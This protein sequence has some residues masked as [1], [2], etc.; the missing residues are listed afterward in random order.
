MVKDGAKSHPGPV[1]M[2]L[3]KQYLQ[4]N[5][6]IFLKISDIICQIHRCSTEGER[7]LEENFRRLYQRV[8]FWRK[9]GSL[10][11][12]NHSSSKGCVWRK[13]E[14]R[15]SWRRWKGAQDRQRGSSGRKST[16][17]SSSNIRDEAGKTG[18]NWRVLKS[19]SGGGRDATGRWIPSEVRRAHWP[20]YS[21]TSEEYGATAVTDPFS[22]EMVQW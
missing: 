12:V 15:R 16:T 8:G 14:C 18:G 1:G 4:S 6:N 13:N 22:T 3:S 20:V 10:V 17:M 7:W 5:K 9:H 2:I 11:S 21:Y 19:S